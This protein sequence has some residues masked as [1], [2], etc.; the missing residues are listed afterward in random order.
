MV[1][2]K[3]YYGVELDVDMLSSKSVCLT[4]VLHLSQAVWCSTAELLHEIPV[5]CQDLGWNSSNVRLLLLM[6]TR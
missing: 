1:L 3:G 4:D 2:S 5:S 6:S